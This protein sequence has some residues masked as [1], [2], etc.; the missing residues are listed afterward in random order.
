MLFFPFHHFIKSYL[1]MH[2]AQNSDCWLYC[3]WVRMFAR[4]F[5]EMKIAVQKSC[6]NCTTYKDNVSRSHHF[7]FHAWINKCLPTIFYITNSISFASLSSLTPFPTSLQRPYSLRPSHLQQNL[8]PSDHHIALIVL[9][10]GSTK[11]AFAKIFAPFY[12][13]LALLF[14]PQMSKQS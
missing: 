5:W 9:K 10:W 11:E 8:L 4:Q 12:F 1:D 7:V 13:P 6:S 14:T 3:S 2:V